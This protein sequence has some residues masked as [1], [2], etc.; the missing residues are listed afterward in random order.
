MLMADKRFTD[1]IEETLAVIAPTVKALEF[2]CS[3]R[4]RSDVLRARHVSAHENS[5]TAFLHL[6]QSSPIR[7][8][9]S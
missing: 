5:A 6:A 4:F 2:G 8:A 3:G 9:G 1:T 7:V